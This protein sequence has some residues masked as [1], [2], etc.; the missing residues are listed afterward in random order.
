V[1]SCYNKSQSEVN[2]LADK[3]NGTK[4]DSEIEKSGSPR[5]RSIWGI[6]YIKRK[7]HQRRSKYKHETPAD[8]A[9]RRTADATVAIAIFTVALALVGIFTL[10]E[11]IGGGSD[12]KDLVSAT[13][14]LARAASGQL[15]S[16]QEMARSASGQLGAMRDF[17]A[18]MKDQ[19]NRT[20]ELA[21]KMGDQT[22]ATNRLAAQAARSADTAQD[23]FKF[24]NRPYIGINSVSISF[25][26]A[27]DTALIWPT[28]TP[29][30]LTVLR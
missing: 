29:Q 25:P 9:A 2:A 1:F 5:M 10:V 4:A 22:D 16:M 23:A 13:Q 24:V 21:S 17:A 11:V 7:F 3:D 15:G 12:T 28:S 19:A 14:N 20:K 8:K 30:P 6:S 26:E 18:R 27:A